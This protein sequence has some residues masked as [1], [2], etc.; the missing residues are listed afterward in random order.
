MSCGLK[1][2]KLVLIKVDIKLLGV[3]RSIMSK[4]GVKIFHFN[5]AQDLQKKKKI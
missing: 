3:K 1:K 4:I 2:K 5:L